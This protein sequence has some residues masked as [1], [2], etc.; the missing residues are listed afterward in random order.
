MR[1]VSSEI[2]ETHKSGISF[3]EFTGQS[4]KNNQGH[5]KERERII[6]QTQTALDSS[7][8]NSLQIHQS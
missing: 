2:F 4:T 1:D 7:R 5:F 6:T 8:H 3:E